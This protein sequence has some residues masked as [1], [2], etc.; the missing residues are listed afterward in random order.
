MESRVINNNYNRLFKVESSILFRCC[1]YK[2]DTKLYPIGQNSHRRL[3][4]Q[5]N[6]FTEQLDEYTHSKSETWLLVQNISVLKSM[7]TIILLL[8]TKSV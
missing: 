2:R 3:G 4:N 7:E 6:E 8:I 5:D 1:T